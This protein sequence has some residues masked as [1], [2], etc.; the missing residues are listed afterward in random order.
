MQLDAPS[1]SLAQDSCLSPLIYSL[2]LNLFLPSGC[3]RMRC[4]ASRRQSSTNIFEEYHGTLTAFFMHREAEDITPPTEEL[5]LLRQLITLNK[6]GLRVKEMGRWGKKKKHKGEG[7]P[8]SKHLQLTC[9]STT[10]ALLSLC[11]E[12]RTATMSRPWTCC[13]ISCFVFLG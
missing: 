13:S 7:W 5:F 10:F 4:K 6:E 11:S 1:C 2:T 8:D 12:G 3:L 9:P